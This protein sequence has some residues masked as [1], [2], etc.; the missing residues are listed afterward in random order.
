MD[1]KEGQADSKKALTSYYK[2]GWLSM[3]VIIT[4]LYLSLIWRMLFLRQPPMEYVDVFSALNIGVVAFL[5]LAQ[6]LEMFNEENLHTPIIRHTLLIG[7]SML[8]I[9][10]LFF[11]AFSIAFFA[12][13]LLGLGIAWILGEKLISK[14]P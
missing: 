13:S 8:I 2:A 7:V 10:M 6:R 1:F 4:V 5:M 14:L 12:T 11:G 9:N 3:M